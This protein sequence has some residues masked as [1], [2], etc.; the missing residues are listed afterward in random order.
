MGS[1]LRVAAGIAGCLGRLITQRIIGTPM[2]HTIPRGR[3]GFTLIEILI[4]TFIIGILMG[5]GIP[6]YLHSRA[7]AQR[8]MCREDR[9]TADR[10]LQIY[11]HRE[12][13]TPEDIQEVI[14]AGYVSPF[15][16]PGGGTYELRFPEGTEEET[17]TYHPVPYLWC[18]VHGSD[19]ETE[20]EEEGPELEA[21]PV[22]EPLPDPD[23]P[24]ARR[25]RR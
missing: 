4:V 10:W 20:E 5:I 24:P 23:P 15:R 14:D 19:H 13:Q 7:G 9:R 8:D 17:A 11:V 3:C 22:P 6:S 2:R 18:S 25:P 21:E 16:C 12:Q 1:R